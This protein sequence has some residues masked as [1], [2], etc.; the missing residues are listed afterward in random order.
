MEGTSGGVHW[1]WNCSI[2]KELGRSLFRKEKGK[3]LP[4]QIQEPGQSLELWEGRGLR[5][6]MGINPQ[7]I[8]ELLAQ[9][10]P[11]ES[12]FFDGLQ[13]LGNELGWGW[14]WTR[15]LPA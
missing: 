9:A 8:Q 2:G 4:G 7:K 10:F 6:G 11:G 1:D 12:G 14:D 13:P 15:T 5:P 3:V